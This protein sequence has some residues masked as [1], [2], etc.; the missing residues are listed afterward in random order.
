MNFSTLDYL[1][2]DAF[3]VQISE[4]LVATTDRS[5]SLVDASVSEVLRM[6][7]EHLNMDVVYVS[8]FLDGQVVL[9]RMDA[10]DERNVM[11]SVGESSPIEQSFCQRVV[12]GRIPRLVRDL[13][14]LP[15][16]ADL[17][18][19]GLPIG[20]HLSTPIVLADGRV[21]GMFC[22]FSFAS[23]EELT[24]RDLRKL[25]MCANLAA[26]KINVQRARES[27]LTTAQWNLEP[28]ESR[29]RR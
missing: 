5:D 12:D 14:S 4:M 2:P 11:F 13:Q 17:P 9:R 21:Y 23:N 22:C 15:D 3:E 8:E 19:T 10:R 6:V 27:E 18:R 25:E 1:E 20:A 29:R 26:R 16:N 24:E 7:K 28:Q